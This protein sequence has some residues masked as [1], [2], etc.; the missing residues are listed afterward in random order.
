[1]TGNRYFFITQETI[2]SDYN[3]F[4]GG[5]ILIRYT[6]YQNGILLN[7]FDIF[8]IRNSQFD[9]IVFLSHLMNSIDYMCPPNPL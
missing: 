9:K 5:Y 4:G 8:I 7:D 2:D 6:I 3:G 1:V